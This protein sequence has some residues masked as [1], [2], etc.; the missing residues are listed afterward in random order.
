MR[1]MNN[2]R[3]VRLPKEDVEIVE[4]I[5]IKIKKDKSTTVRGLI[6]QGKIYFA[7]KEYSEGNISLGKAAEISGLSISEIMNIFSKF[8][9]KSN[10]DVNDYLDGRKV[11]E[12]LI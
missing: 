3:T 8:G 1:R 6:E 10:M 4:Q 12:E 5:S 11:A 2:I 7:I 9:V